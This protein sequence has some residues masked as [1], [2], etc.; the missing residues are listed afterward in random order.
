MI[1]RR[2]IRSERGSLSHAMVVN[3]QGMKTGKNSARAMEVL[4]G[5]PARGAT[6]R[7]MT[8]MTGANLTYSSHKSVIEYMF[9]VGSWVSRL[10]MSERVLRTITTHHHR[11]LNLHRSGVV[12]FSRDP[13]IHASLMSPPFERKISWIYDSVQIHKARNYFSLQTCKHEEGKPVEADSR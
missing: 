13:T 9:S 12:D 5:S 11:V 7:W 10:E 4:V 1:D 2:S 8:T 6:K 3:L